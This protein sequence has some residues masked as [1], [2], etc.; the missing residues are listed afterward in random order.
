M[1]EISGI[2]KKYGMDY[3]VYNITFSAEAGEPVGIFGVKGAGKTTIADII[4]GCVYAD[5]GSVKLN[6]YDILKKPKKAKQE[7]GYVPESSSL[8]N[9]MTADE[10]LKFVCSV[11]RVRKDTIDNTVMTVLKSARI[12]DFGEQLIGRLGKCERQR[13]ALA[14]AL[15]GDPAVLIFDE[16]SAR[17]DP[18]EAEE[19]RSI[20]KS[21]SEEHAVIVLSHIVHDISEIC[22]KVIILNK[23]RITA[24]QPL[25]SLRGNSE[26]RKR[27]LVRL[28]AEKHTAQKVL[29]GIEDADFVDCLGCNEA[30][31]CD[32]IVESLGND[33]RAQI[34]NAA[35][36]S[37]MTLLGMTPL[38]VTLEDIFMQL[39]GNG[40]E[41]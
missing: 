35:V 1:I 11:K 2:C 34:F 6:G 39:T 16:P 25:E 12:P 37:K 5:S 31:T 36:D 4:S 20:I 10:Y 19:M 30:G 33:L 15:C 17:L 3:V 28:A 26:S 40:G 9:D 22:S 27:I 14:A 18:D 32:F 13:L 7:I 21:L 24:Q 23:G 8:Y 41:A 38:N 29:R